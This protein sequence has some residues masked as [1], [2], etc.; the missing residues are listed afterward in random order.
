MFPRYSSEQRKGSGCPSLRVEKPLGGL[1][2]GGW[3]DAWCGRQF[4][5]SVRR[6]RGCVTY[7][8]GVQ[9]WH[10]GVELSL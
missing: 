9:V 6:E 1:L 4:E 8:G 3:W 7:K 2:G 10:S 5:G